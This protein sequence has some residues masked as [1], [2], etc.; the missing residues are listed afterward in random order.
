VLFFSPRSARI[1]VKL[2][3]EA[4]LGPALESAV[5]FCLS[6]AIAEAARSASWRD[7]KSAARPDEEAMLALIQETQRGP[8]KP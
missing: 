7:A 4:T 6:P 1:F 2:A 8:L 3:L 5:A